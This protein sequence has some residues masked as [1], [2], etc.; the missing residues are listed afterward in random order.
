MPTRKQRNYCTN[1]EH[2]LQFIKEYL[3]RITE[4]LDFITVELQ[5]IKW[6][7]QVS[8]KYEHLEK[9]QKYT[10]IVRDYIQS[11]EPQTDVILCLMNLENNFGWPS[12]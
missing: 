3:Q 5:E 2:L 9:P 4:S 12:N 11:P 8:D 1:D 7:L 6:H 10:E